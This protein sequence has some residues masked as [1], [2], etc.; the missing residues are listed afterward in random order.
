MSILYGLVT[1]T[2]MIARISQAE[3]ELQFKLDGPEIDWIIEYGYGLPR[4]A[5][6]GSHSQDESHKVTEYLVHSRAAW[7]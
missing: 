2:L 3:A 5:E 7:F 6:W 1:L 4:E